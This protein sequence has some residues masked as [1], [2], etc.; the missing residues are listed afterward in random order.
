VLGD[1]HRR[2]PSPTLQNLGHLVVQRYPH[3]LGEALQGGLADQVVGEATLAQDTGGLEL[4]L[5]LGQRQ[6]T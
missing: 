6:G 5:G 1:Y 2:H 3:R 4:V